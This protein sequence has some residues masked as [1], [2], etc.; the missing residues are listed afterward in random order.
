MLYATNYR[1]KK[2]LDITKFEVGDKVPALIKDFSPSRDK[3]QLAK[4]E[5]VKS[6]IKMVVDMVLDAVNVFSTFGTGPMIAHLVK[7]NEL[8]GPLKDVTLLKEWLSLLQKIFN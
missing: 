3:L 7:M 8:K 2:L 1:L 4:C 5:L 6:T